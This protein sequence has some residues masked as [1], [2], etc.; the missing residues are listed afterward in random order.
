MGFRVKKSFIFVLAWFLYTMF[1]CKAKQL[2]PE[3]QVSALSSNE[4]TDPCD[5]VVSPYFSP[6]TYNLRNAEYVESVSMFR[7][8]LGWRFPGNTICSFDLNSLTPTRETKKFTSLRRKNIRLKYPDPPNQK[9]DQRDWVYVEFYCNGNDTKL[10]DKFGTPCKI[11]DAGWVKK[12]LLNRNEGS[13]RGPAALN[14]KRSRWG[15]SACLYT[16]KGGKDLKVYKA[17]GPDQEIAYTL[18][19]P[20]LYPGVAWKIAINYGDE[21]SP[22]N[23]QRWNMDDFSLVQMALDENRPD[24]KPTEVLWVFIETLNGNIGWRP[25]LVQ[26][27][28]WVPYSRLK[29]LA[30]EKTYLDPENPDQTCGEFL[31]DYR[32]KSLKDNE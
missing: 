21:K 19:G 17:P 32:K 23:P 18:K 29:L 7:T 14:P 3:E 24:E 27:Q 28:G 12:E 1:A 15:R 2:E 25:N 26:R 5:E 4:S 30:K 31:K 22:K 8:T 6:V 11:G 20:E 10:G 9:N 16:F 13:G